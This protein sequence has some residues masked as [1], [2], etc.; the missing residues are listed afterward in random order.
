MAGLEDCLG[1][2]E[3]RPE[4]LHAER[5][6]MH[7]S[8]RRSAKTLQRISSSAIFKKIFELGACHPRFFTIFVG[9][10]GR[11]KGG[12]M[13]S[14]KK[15]AFLLTP[16]PAAVVREEQDDDGNLRVVVLRAA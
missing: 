14:N 1:C 7:H 3:F 8:P 4:N 2:H 6:G 16:R 5:R 10:Q 12:Q 15:I 13:S 11:Q 9:G